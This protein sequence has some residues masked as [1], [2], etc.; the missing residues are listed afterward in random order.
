MSV[1]ANLRV[2]ALVLWCGIAVTP[3]QAMADDID[4]FLGTSGGSDVA[5]VVVIMQNRLGRLPP[6]GNE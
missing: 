6:W 1:F 5:P 3:L 4:L 2:L